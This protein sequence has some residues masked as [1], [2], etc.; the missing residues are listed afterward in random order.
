MR[1]YIFTV[2]DNETEVIKKIEELKKN[3]KLSLTIREL[4]KKYLQDNPEPQPQTTQSQSST[5]Q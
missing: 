5:S 1:A 2:P 3:K 4:F